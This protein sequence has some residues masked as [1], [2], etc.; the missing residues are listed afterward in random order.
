MLKIDK[1]NTIIEL[2]EEAKVYFNAFEVT[3][4]FSFRIYSEQLNDDANRLEMEFDFEYE[5]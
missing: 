5:L 2:R 3:G 4:D 1:V